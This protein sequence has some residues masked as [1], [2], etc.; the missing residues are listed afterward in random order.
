MK[1]TDLFQNEPLKYQVITMSIL[2]VCIIFVIVIIFFRM[3][4]EKKVTKAALELKKIT[5]SIHAGLVHFVMEDNCR[6]LYASK[7]F[8][9][10]L[11]YTKEEAR[12]DN[13]NSILDFINPRDLYIFDSSRGNLDKNNIS[14]EIRML[15]KDKSSIYAL[16]NG[17]RAVN[18]DGK[19]MVSVVFVDISKQKNMQDIILLEGEKY[20]I[21]AELSKD[22]LF[23]YHI[24]KDQMIFSEK[25]K[26][27]YG[28]NSV[29]DGLYNYCEDRRPL[30]HPD[31]WGIYLE[32]CQELRRGKSIIN[33]EYRVKDRLGDY[34]WTQLMGKTIYDDDKKPIRVIGKIVNVDIQKRELE[35][36]EYKATRD[37]LTG[38]YN[39]EVTIKKI[40][41][42]IS[43]N[44]N[45]KHML[46]FI[47][48]DDFKNVNDSY[49]HLVGDKVLTF[50]I[51][52]IKEVFSEGEIIGR[53]G[54]DEFIVFS[55]N[56]INIEDILKKAESILKV[57]NVTYT[58]EEYS[59][60]ISGSI[61]ISV[62][63]ED[64][65]YYEQL[66][67]KADKALYS[68][69]KKGKNNYMLYNSEILSEKK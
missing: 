49:G 57:L 22:I 37:P 66:L 33:C 62:Y 31:D 23:E 53:T 39:K 17:N 69:K 40:D 25:Y 20:R 42:F 2:F 3:E 19:H 64:G 63:P 50:V 36:L 4:S 28:R 13:K 26:D 38:V 30:V 27:L 68:V 8:Y 15:K 1:L 16:M 48:F 46:M 44:R 7:G 12:K 18:K 47:D 29:I 41:K 59:I 52:Q 34:I 61:G 58:T 60:P 24:N 35:A 21:A 9:E 5:N 32:L 11:G 43:G 51:S 45:N 6:I 10:L 56:I 14:Y 54:G 65:L 67:E 55:G